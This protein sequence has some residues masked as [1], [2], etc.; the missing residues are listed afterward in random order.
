MFTTSRRVAHTSHLASHAQMLALAA[1]LV[2]GVATSAEAQTRIWNQ[3]SDAWSNPLNWS[4]SD[5]P[6]SGAESASFG[7]VLAYVVSMNA[8]YSIGGISISNPLA[9]LNIS[10]TLVLGLGADSTNNGTIVVNSSGANNVTILSINNTFTMGGTGSIV[11]NANAANL[12][13]AY[14]YFNNGANVLTNGPSHTIRGTG[15][16]YTNIANS[17]TIQADVSGATLQLQSQNKSNSGTM[18]AINGG[19][20]AITG[21]GITQSGGQIVAASGTV[22]VTNSTI[23]GGSVTSTGGTFQAVGT[24]TFDGVTVAGPIVVSPNSTLAVGGTGLTN[25]STI[26]LNPAGVNTS[27]ILSCNG[28]SQTIGGTGSIVLNANA[29]NLDSAYL[30]FNS[31]ANVLT[32]GAGQTLR[33][34]GNVYTN[35]TNNGVVQADVSSRTMQLQSQT[36]TNNNLMRATNAGTLLANGFTLN[37]GPSGIVRADGGTVQLNNATLN[38]GALQSINGGSMNI[39]GSTLLNAVNNQN[40]LNVMPNSTLRVASGMVNNGTILLNPTGVGGVSIL[41]IDA[42]ASTITG[43]GSIVLN[44]DPSNLDLA[45]MYFNNGANVFTLPA[46][47]TIRGTGSIYTN[48]A[49]AGTIRADVS[50]RVLKLHSQPKSNSSV[51]EAVGS[52]LLNIDGIAISQSSSGEIRADGGTVSLINSSITG[53]TIRS[54]N[55]GA[56]NILG[57]TTLQS[58]TNAD[59]INVLGGGQLNV[60]SNGLVNNGRIIV[61]PTTTGTAIL[62]LNS[63]TG[64]IT[65]NG[66]ILLNA[67]AANPDLAYLYFN[68]GSN[69]LT[70]G[71]GQTLAGNGRS[72]P[73]LDMQGTFAPGTDADATATLHFNNPVVMTPSATLDIQIAGTAA[74]DFDRLA[75]S[76][77]FT[78]DGLVRVTLINGFTNP[79]IGTSFDV[80][81]APT[82][83]G[84][85]LHSDLPRGWG[86]F[87][88]PGVLRVQYTG[89]LADL[90]CGNG[91]GTPD[92]GVDINDLLYFLTQF[93][94]GTETAD[95]DDGSGTGTTDGGVDINDLLFF[96]IRFQSGC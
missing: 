15:N 42:A 80:V 57:S 8:S 94:A 34:T 75:S 7:G 48:I 20:L 3:S 28:A 85:C 33:G 16:V 40:V 6:D 31:G 47:Q 55:A 93:E 87:A 84:D 18:R 43:T 89:C 81:T 72:Y 45:Y 11:L 70:I 69:V 65:G 59:T 27:T 51:M 61:N 63:A 53:G 83:L 96:L 68:N 22:S 9:S 78:V 86:V 60:N 24:G 52:G 14:M 82:V 30:Y 54:L 95:L 23:T 4:P 71:P 66:T 13:S 5:V 76:Q 67:S 19:T 25:N 64:A 73:R 50:G 17:G 46:T 41:S 79:A 36:K 39:T 49:N 37:Q 91:T 62:A 2:A 92:G 90:D 74:A 56:V 44:A 10:P 29:A 1:G 35:I 38:N 26:T 88:M 58:T 12:D 32:L 21:I 77:P